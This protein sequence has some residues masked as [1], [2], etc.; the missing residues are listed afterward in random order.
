MLSNSLSGDWFIFVKVKILFQGKRTLGTEF[1]LAQYTT[2]QFY[3]NR[4]LLYFGVN[5][6]GG[7]LEKSTLLFLLWK[8][9]LMLIQIKDEVRNERETYLFILEY[10][11]MF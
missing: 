7:S 1:F 6:L 3:K 9:S 10:A 5:T 8:T 4:I 2:N 11:M